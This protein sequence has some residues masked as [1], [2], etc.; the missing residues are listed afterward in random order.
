MLIDKFR[1]RLCESHVCL[2]RTE[3]HSTSEVSGHHLAD[4]LLLL[5]GNGINGCNPF[6][7]TI[8]RIFE[9][10]T[11][12]EFSAHNL[13]ICDLTEMLLDCGLIYKE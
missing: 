7:L 8:L 11:F 3:F 12:G 9:V 4:L 5:S 10:L 1:T 13:E 2:C 6:F